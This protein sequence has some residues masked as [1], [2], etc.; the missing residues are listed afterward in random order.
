MLDVMNI[1]R[2]AFCLLLLFGLITTVVMSLVT[3]PSHMWLECP[4]VAGVIDASGRCRW[5]WL[6]INSTTRTGCGT[7]ELYI[8][9]C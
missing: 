5:R 9:T 7:L 6:Q 4:H 1:A 8:A 3:L 2:N